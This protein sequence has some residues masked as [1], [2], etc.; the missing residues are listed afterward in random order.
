MDVLI[1]DGAGS[2]G[3][4]P[5]SVSVNVEYAD[6]GIA[7]T[8]L[9]HGCRGGQQ[10]DLAAGVIIFSTQQIKA[11]GGGSAVPIDGETGAGIA[12]AG[13]IP[14][15]QRCPLR[16]GVGRIAGLALHLQRAGTDGG[17]PGEGAGAA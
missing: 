12:A 7:G 17:R 13:A 11:R 9:A 5:E 14:D 10:H 15:F 2:G 1:Q 3:G 6:I 8:V 16:Y 4:A